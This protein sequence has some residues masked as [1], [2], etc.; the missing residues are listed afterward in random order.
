MVFAD[1]WKRAATWS[2]VS[3]PGGLCSVVRWVVIPCSRTAVGLC[4][5]APAFGVSVW[6]WSVCTGPRAAAPRGRVKHLQVRPREG[7]DTAGGRPRIA[8]RQTGAIEPAGLGGECVCVR[9]LGWLGA[10]VEPAA[11][12]NLIEG[13]RLNA[14]HDGFAVLLADPLRGDGAA[15]LVVG[16]E[17][18]RAGVGV[19]EEGID[20][21]EDALARVVAEVDLEEHETAAHTVGRGAA[22]DA[23]GTVALCVWLVHRQQVLG[24]EPCAEPVAH[25]VGRD[26]VRHR[27]VGQCG[28]EAAPEPGLRSVG[29]AEAEGGACRWADAG[30]PPGP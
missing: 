16:P 30:G 17:Q 27:A 3:T 15:P 18:D 5:T 9:P 2:T 8:G 13:E 29:A 23:V 19:V 11:F 28:A 22:V 4:R 26:L 21:P 6:I 1:S 7:V 25:A 14:V 20:L 12:A 10:W 24:Q